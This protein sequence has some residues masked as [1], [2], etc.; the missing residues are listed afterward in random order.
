MLEQRYGS[1]SR[2]R[3]PLVITVAVLLAAAAVG[4]LVWATS[5]GRPQ[6][7]SALLSYD[8]AGEHSAQAKLTVV[9]R[10]TGVHASCLL[11]AM[12][13]DHSVVGELTFTVDRSSPASLTTKKV[14]RTERRATAVQLVGCVAKGQD[15]R[16]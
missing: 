2:A 13:E 11:R 5:H 12:A 4:W 10:D 7:Q 9:R 8:V 1:P 14:L 16:R 15:Q 6:V 3:R